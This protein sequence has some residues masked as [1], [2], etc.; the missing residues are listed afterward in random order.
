MSPVNKPQITSQREAEPL[1]F[2][3]WEEPA[4]WLAAGAVLVAL[5]VIVTLLALG[6]IQ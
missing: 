1:R 5:A 4:D 6:G 2:A 3:F